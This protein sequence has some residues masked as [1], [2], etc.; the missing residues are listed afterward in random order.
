MIVDDEFEMNS[1][2]VVK[3]E[4]RL[5]GVDDSFLSGEEVLVVGTIFRGGEWLD[6]VVRT[7]I[8]RD[9]MNATERLSRMVRETRHYR[10]LR[11]ILLDGITFAGFNVVDIERLCHETGLPVIA[12]MRRVPDF[13]K[14]RRA[15]TYL[16]DGEERW[17]L[18]LRA[19]RIVRVVTREP[20]RP[21]HIQFT[22][23]HEED[24]VQ[25]V[26]LSSTRSSIPEP[27]R[28]AHLIATGIACGESK[29]RS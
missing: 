2:F 12:I 5:L 24:A 27:L 9:G 21:I 25:I 15:L 1:R 13:E 22:G 26:R 10:Q 11:A 7:T 28:A 20:D 14:I 3:P 23:L 19:G 6:G 8:T 4:I 18:I 16:S 17:E 29:R